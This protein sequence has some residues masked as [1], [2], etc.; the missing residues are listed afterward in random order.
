MFER[1]EWRA[2]ACRFQ[3]RRPLQPTVTLHADTPSDTLLAC[4]F[5][6]PCPARAAQSLHLL[7]GLDCRRFRRTSFRLLV[8]CP[9]SSKRSPSGPISAN[10]LHRFQLMPLTIHRAVSRGPFWMPRRAAPPRRPQSSLGD[11]GCTNAIHHVKGLYSGR[12]RTSPPKKDARDDQAMVRYGATASLE[13]VR[14]GS[15]D[16]DGRQTTA[17][18]AAG[19]VRSPQ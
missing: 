10:E 19:R 17:G 9:P 16:A 5:K 12:F 3:V 7:K 18:R 4:D 13:L 8:T 6:A 14:R 2:L 11:T 1:K 15:S